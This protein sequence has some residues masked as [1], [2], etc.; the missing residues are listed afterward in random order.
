MTPKQLN[1]PFQITSVCRADICNISKKYP[2]KFIESLDNGDMEHISNK[3]A[4]AY[5][6]CCFWVALESLCDNLMREKGFKK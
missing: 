5:L 1:K 4:D 6:E 3:M 2:K